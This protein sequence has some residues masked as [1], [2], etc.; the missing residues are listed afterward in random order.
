MRLATATSG[1]LVLALI[2]IGMSLFGMLYVLPA[3]FNKNAT[4][5]T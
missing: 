1:R 5:K 4:W 2:G 3:A